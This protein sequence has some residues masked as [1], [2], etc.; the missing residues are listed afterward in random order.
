VSKF[1]PGPW[2]ADG[3][4]V[5]STDC[6]HHAV[7]NCSVNHTCRSSDEAEANASLVAAAPELLEALR[8]A[9]RALGIAIRSAW[10]GSTDADVAENH[11]IKK[12]DAALALVQP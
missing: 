3:V 4:E 9:R 7:A 5:Y 2:I 12:I 1:T 10:E 11:V 8:D 6:D